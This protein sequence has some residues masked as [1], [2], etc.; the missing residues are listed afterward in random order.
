M[1]QDTGAG[2]P[3]KCRIIEWLPTGI[4]EMNMDIGITNRWSPQIEITDQPSLIDQSA[5]LAHRRTDDEAPPPCP[6]AQRPASPD[7]GRSVR[8][9][10][11]P[12]FIKSPI[13]HIA[14]ASRPRVL[15]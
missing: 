5:D 12:C 7:F 14:G 9:Q 4:T 13:D 8:R 10:I 11:H 6:N 1:A 15:R 3:V 2:D